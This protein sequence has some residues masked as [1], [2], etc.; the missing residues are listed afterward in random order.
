M[1]GMYVHYFSFALTYK[2][3]FAANKVIL[4]NLSIDLI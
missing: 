1:S 4:S 2:F 3:K